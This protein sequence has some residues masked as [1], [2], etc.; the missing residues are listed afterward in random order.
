MFQ[1]VCYQPETSHA[2]KNARWCAQSCTVTD[3]KLV[4]L[5]TILIDK[6]YTCSHASCI[7]ET[8]DTPVYYSTWTALQHHMRTSHPPVCPYPSCNGK[9]FSA[10]KGLRAHLKIHEQREAESNLTSSD[11]ESDNEP[12]RKKRRGGELGRDWVCDVDGCTKDFKSVSR[13]I[14]S[15]ERLHVD[16][17]K[18]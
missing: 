10:Q 12:S 9:T 3:H 6:R 11:P 7:V 4:A 8:T 1:F 16:G 2:L 13:L 5:T 14:S 15:S 18:R 17:V